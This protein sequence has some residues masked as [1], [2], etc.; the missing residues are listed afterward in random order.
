MDPTADWALLPRLIALAGVGRLLL[1]LLPAGEP[2][3]GRPRE[4]PAVLAAS[5]VLGLLA[6]RATA[7]AFEVGAGSVGFLWAFF[8]T[9]GAVAAGRALAL[10]F[11]PFALAPLARGPEA[12]PAEALPARVLRAAPLTIAAFSVAVRART[13][14]EGSQDGALHAAL[15]GAALLSWIS[16]ARC[17]RVRPVA[18]DAL[19]LVAAVMLLVHEGAQTTSQGALTLAAGALGTEGLVRWSF[20]AD[21]RGRALAVLAGALHA[22][23]GGGAAGVGLALGIGLV[24][25]SARPRRSEV[26]Q[27]AALL[28]LVSLGAAVHAGWS[29]T[30]ASPDGWILAAV[31][32][33]PWVVLQVRPALQPADGPSL[34]PRALAATG[35]ALGA[36]VAL[37]HA[38]GTHGLLA[39]PAAS[40]GVLLAWGPRT[41]RAPQVRVTPAAPHSESATPGTRGTETP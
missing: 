23:G 32:V 8:G 26:A 17:L 31:A 35:A 19:A 40:L 4:L 29:P 34:A 11:G 39:L 9:A 18:I 36:A 37:G 38:P 33:M 12:E 13:G 41:A 30:E 2:G 24:A 21:R 16:A 28:A 27:L 14:L 5:L 6:V 22:V 7:D 1:A 10:R 15:E 20:R 3:G 25:A